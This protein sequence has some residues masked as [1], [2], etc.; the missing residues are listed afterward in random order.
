M[1]TS[2]NTSLEVRY[3]VI[4]PI[5]SP[6]PLS[7]TMSRHFAPLVS[8]FYI[9]LHHWKSWWPRPFH[10]SCGPRP[11]R[12]WAPWWNSCLLLFPAQI[13]W[14]PG[15]RDTS[16]GVPWWLSYHPQT[17]ILQWLDTLAWS[18][19]VESAS[20]IS[21]EVSDIML[22]GGTV[23]AS[24]LHL[25]GLPNIYWECSACSPS[26]HRSSFHCMGFYCL[27]NHILW[28][29]NKL[30][31]ICFLIRRYLFVVPEWLVLLRDSETSMGTQNLTLLF[32]FGFGFLYC[33]PCGHPN[34]LP[35]KQSLHPWPSC[36]PDPRLWWGPWPR[37][38]GHPSMVHLHLHQDAYL[39]GKIRVRLFLSWTH[40]DYLSMW[41]R[42]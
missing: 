6:S 32:I 35:S 11:P 24:R 27:R 21:Y 31:N 14:S 40:W 9:L 41:G 19:W 10:L 20:S 36:Q 33:L 13:W 42:A 12:R 38:C 28:W 23:W 7:S 8:R 17:H 16:A 15:G 1:P 3:K 2:F 26:S 4:S 18:L 25:S 34:R 37:P 29:N 30:P 39:G 22:T 5:L